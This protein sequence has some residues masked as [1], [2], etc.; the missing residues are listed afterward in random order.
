MRK[1]NKLSKK[2]IKYH[3]EHKS[4]LILLLIV[5]ILFVF[6]ISILVF[7]GIYF[8]FKDILGIIPVFIISFGIASIIYLFLIIKVLK[9]F[10]F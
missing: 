5:K 6:L 7:G 1:K 4:R 3:I 10:K 2:N 9:L 8:L